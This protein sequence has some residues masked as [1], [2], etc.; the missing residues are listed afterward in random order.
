MASRPL[1]L[2]TSGIGKGH[3]EFHGFG[4]LAHGLVDKLIKA[5]DE[6]AGLLRVAFQHRHQIERLRLERS[7][8]TG[9]QSHGAGG[10]LLIDGIPRNELSLFDL[11]V[12]LFPVGGVLDAPDFMLFLFPLASGGIGG[13]LVRRPRRGERRR[14]SP[15]MGGYVFFVPLLWYLLAGSACL[16]ASVMPPV[17]YGGSVMTASTLSIG[18]RRSIERA[19][20]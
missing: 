14:V 9:G 6:R 2:I 17:E 3:F 7:L 11:E 20:P 15:N 12:E 19:S 1:F 5:F 10:K 13:Q 8:Q 18:N 16:L 4:V